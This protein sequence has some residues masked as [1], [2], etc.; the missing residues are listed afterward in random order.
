[1]IIC[2]KYPLAMASR[3]AAFNGNTLLIAGFYPDA[4]GYGEIAS[5]GGADDEGLGLCHQKLEAFCCVN[6]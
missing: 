6:S 4:M 2:L 3:P 1:M 5:I